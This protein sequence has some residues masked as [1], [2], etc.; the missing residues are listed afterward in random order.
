[1][2]GLESKR[3]LVM[4]REGKDSGVQDRDVGTALWV[5]VGSTGEREGGAE[6]TRVR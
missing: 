3:C 6:E 4:R 2:V 5:T 1:M